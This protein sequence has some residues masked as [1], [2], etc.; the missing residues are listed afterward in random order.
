MKYKVLFA[1]DPAG[2]GSIENTGIAFGHRLNIIPALCPCKAG[3]CPVGMY[4]L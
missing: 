3:E 1:S 4:E 2:R